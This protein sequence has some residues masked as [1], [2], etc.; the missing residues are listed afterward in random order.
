MRING[1]CV[2]IA[3][4]LGACAGCEPPGDAIFFDIM[5]RVGRDC[6]LA[7]PMPPETPFDADGGKR[8]KYLAAF[9]DGYLQ[10]VLGIRVIYCVEVPEES[11]EAGWMDGQ[12]SGSL[13][14][15]KA[16]AELLGKR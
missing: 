15:M 8:A 11:R 13:T 12:E 7:V 1:A 2:T 5:R 14:L 6:S 9:R 10:A 3:L 16:Y 4:A